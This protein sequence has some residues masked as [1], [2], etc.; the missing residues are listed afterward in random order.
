MTKRRSVKATLQLSI[1]LFSL[2]LAAC[3]LFLMLGYAWIVEDSVFN[4][5][6]HAEARYLERQHR[7]TGET[8]EPRY[9]FM[10]LHPGWHALPEAIQRLHQ[11]SPERIEFP[12]GSNGT[13]HIQ[14]LLLDD[15][16]WVLVADVS[17]L[18]VTSRYLPRILPYL[19]LT[20][21]LVAG[22][23]LALAYYLSQSI[24]RPIQIL[25]ARVEQHRQGI[26]F[27]LDT[28]LPD[29]EIRYLG[30]TI[31]NSFQHLELALAREADFTRDVS[32][33]LRTPATVMKM[34][35]SR[36]NPA[37]PPGESSLTQLKQSALQ[38]E[39]TIHALLALAREE[40][41]QRESLCLLEAI[42]HCLVNHPLLMQQSSLKLQLQVPADYSVQA[43]RNLLHILLINVIDNAL[44]HAS[45]LQLE[46]TLNKD[47]LS[48]SN[49]Y[50]GDIPDAALAPGVKAKSSLGIG[51]G[52]HIVNRICARYQ[53]RVASQIRDGQFLLTIQ[54]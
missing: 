34:I 26:P 46:F 14:P 25:S 45:D 5:L 10:K 29:N 8:T 43:N 54:F 21:A 3:L 1:T 38:M 32:H 31:L 2:L 6:V 47:L 50:Q 53:W 24:V 22:L 36:L 28:G 49:P 52:L 11:E 41:M 33:E 13:L 48:I 40:S 30:Q 51:Q 39:Q 4:Q 9:P 44:K 27:N 23:A 18:E 42:E 19:L 37:S 20:L 16:Q 35:L 15:T 12:S 17:A 7:E